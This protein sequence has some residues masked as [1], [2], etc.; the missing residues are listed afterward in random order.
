M[1]SLHQML[2]SC[3]QKVGDLPRAQ[4]HLKIHKTFKAQVDEAA[5]KEQE[6]SS[7]R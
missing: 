7:G 3:Y 5:K 2:A 4:S 1:A 6:K